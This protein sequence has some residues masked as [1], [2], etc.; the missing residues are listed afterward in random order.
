KKINNDRGVCFYCAQCNRGCQVYAD[1]S[2]STCLIKP[3]MKNG[4]VDLYT[5]AMVREVLTDDSGQASG[6]SYIYKPDMQEYKIRAKVVVLAASAC[7]TARLL[8]NSKSKIH[9]N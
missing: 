2:S 5:L 8:L 6:V 7:E 3:A 4:Q 1:F 9:L